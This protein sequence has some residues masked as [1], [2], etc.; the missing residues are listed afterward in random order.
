VGEARWDREIHTGSVDG[1]FVRDE[2]GEYHPTQEVLAVPKD[3]TEIAQPAA[4]INAKAQG[5]LQRYADKAEEYLAGKEDRRDHTWRLQR[6]LS[7][8]GF[9]LKEALRVA[10]LSGAAVIASLAKAFP[11]KFKLVT[12][13]KGGASFIELR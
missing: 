2:A 4:K 9:N 7:T 3:S 10:G 13:K 8:E 5:M 1:A 6:V 12:S 11:D